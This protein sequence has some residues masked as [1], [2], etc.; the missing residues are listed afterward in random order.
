MRLIQNPQR[1]RSKTLGR[2][3][4]SSGG[5]RSN[6]TTIDFEH[7]P[8]HPA[9]RLGAQEENDVG[10]LLR[11]ADAV[12]GA[13]AG[14]VLEHL[15]RLALEEELGGDGARGDGVDADAL[16]HE[17]LG[18][19]VD[20]LLDGAFGGAVEEI[21]RHDVGGCGDGGRKMNDFRPRGHVWESFLH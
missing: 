4:D 15:L 11:G 10:D 18:H 19:D 12:G 20:H 9:T 7:L 1:E 16:T 17:V 21:A 6:G 14:D 2:P 5:R 8:A 13:E 3:I